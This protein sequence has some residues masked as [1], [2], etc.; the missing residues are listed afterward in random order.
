MYEQNIP[1]NKKFITF[2]R[3]LENFMS[4]E[5]NKRIKEQKKADEN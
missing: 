4:I 1:D 3:D 2:E 5:L